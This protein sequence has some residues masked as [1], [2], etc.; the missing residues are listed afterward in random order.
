MAFLLILCTIEI[1]KFVTSAI[2]AN[3][4]TNFII[5][6]YLLYLLI[7]YFIIVFDQPKINC[8]LSMTI[9]QDFSHYCDYT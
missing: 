3:L 7:D 8:R 2:Y 1:I 4:L 6:N 9:H 5:A